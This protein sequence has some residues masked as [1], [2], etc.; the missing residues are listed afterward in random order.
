M[1]GTNPQFNG[2]NFRT[3]IRFAMNMGAPV[4]APDRATFRWL[5]HKTYAIQ[6]PTTAPY[7]WDASP[8]TDVSH[9]DVQVPVAVQLG[10]VSPQQTDLGTF[11][12]SKAT[13]TVLDEDYALVEGADLVL[14]GQVVYEIDGVRP[15]EGLFDV[16]IYTI[17][18]RAVES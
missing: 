14:L 6:D 11:N 10:S 15:P 2:A 17:D 12:P 1:A 7:S 16:T 13:L 3:Q 4:N 5:H 9:P 8:A 18:L